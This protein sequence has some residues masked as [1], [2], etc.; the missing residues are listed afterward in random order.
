MKGP[1]LPGMLMHERFLGEK[2]RLFLCIHADPKGAARDTN[3]WTTTLSEGSTKSWGGT[4]WSKWTQDAHD[5]DPE[6]GDH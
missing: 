5:P 4:F 2:E 6:P 3:Y 1:I